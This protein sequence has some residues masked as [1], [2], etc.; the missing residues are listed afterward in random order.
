[1]PT[2]MDTLFK[3]WSFREKSNQFFVFVDIFP[4][5]QDNFVDNYLNINLKTGM[6]LKYVFCLPYHNY[7]VIL[8]S[9]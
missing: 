3:K 9:L 6:L 7:Y 8:H 5:R 1:M 2:K 4:I